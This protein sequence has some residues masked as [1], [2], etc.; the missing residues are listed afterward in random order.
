MTQTWRAGCNCMGC[1]AT[2]ERRGEMTAD[3]ALEGIVALTVLLNASERRVADLERQLAE[4][5]VR[6]ADLEAGVKPLQERVFAQEATI[7]SQNR[8]GF[9]TREERDEA[10]AAAGAIW[11]A[12]EQLIKGTK[13][14][15]DHG[16]DP[17]PFAYDHTPDYWIRVAVT[18]A[19]AALAT[20]IGKEE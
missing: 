19:E 20:D 4:A 3:N 1:V 12:L 17:T 11:E 6:I 5:A 18:C 2:R 8:L 14:L 9:A 10:Q 13:H 15:L 16:R 7:E